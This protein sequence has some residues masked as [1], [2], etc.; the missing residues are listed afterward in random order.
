LMLRSSRRILSKT[1]RSMTK[2]ISTFGHH[3][4]MPRL[5]VPELQST[6]KLYLETLKPLLSTQEYKKIRDYRQRVPI[7]TWKETAT[8]FD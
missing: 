1:S 5:P 2:T 6:C 4:T 8:S 7:W 3:A